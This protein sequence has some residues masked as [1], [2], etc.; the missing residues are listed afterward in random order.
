MKIVYLTE[1]ERR[2]TLTV[3]RSLLQSRREIINKLGRKWSLTASAKAMAQASLQTEIEVI[4]RII[5]ASEE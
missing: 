1:P 5:K 2:T 3:M 4:T